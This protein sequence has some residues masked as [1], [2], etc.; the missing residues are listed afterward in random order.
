MN[1]KKSVTWISGLLALILI[2][3]DFTGT[4]KL[5]G[6]AQYTE[7]M[8]TLHSFFVII[9]PIIPTFFFSLLT[10]WMRE[11]IYRS[12]F[13]FARWWIPLSMVL[14]FLAP[15]YSGDWMYPI[16]KGTVAF[17]TSLVFVIVSIIVIIVRYFHTRPIVRRNSA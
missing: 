6:G 12:W 8:Q 16:E 14:I 4:D 7:C 2:G 3:F 13:R 9:I 17:F 1:V 5:C 15:E 10:Y 11:E